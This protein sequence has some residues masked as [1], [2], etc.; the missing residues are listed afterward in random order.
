M[1]VTDTAIDDTMAVAVVGIVV[2]AAEVVV[3]TVAN[4]LLVDFSS[5]D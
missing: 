3:T 4:A 2:A 1:V 5:V